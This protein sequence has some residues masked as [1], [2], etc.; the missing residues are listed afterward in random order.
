MNSVTLLTDF[1]AKD[2]YVGIMKGVILAINPGLSIVDITHEVEPQD[3]REGAFLIPEY[4]RYFR[5]GT[6]HLCVVD[7]TVGSPRKAMIAARDGHVFV[8]PD[9]GL[10]TM[11]LD[12]A[13]L[14]EITNER[15]FLGEASATFNGRD[16]FSPVAAHLTLGVPPREFGPLLENPVQLAG[17]TPEVRDDRLRG[18]IVKFDRFG[19]AISNISLEDIRSFSGK[20]P[21][22]V[23]I[24]DLS[25]HG[26]NRSYYED[27]QTALIGSSGY[28]EFG[29][30]E[31]NMARE[32]GFVKG[33]QVTVRRL[34]DA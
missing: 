18:E 2:P 17:M 8:G 4:Y 9:N 16:I 7:P 19:N 32:K 28:L 13:D 5:P 23:E 15:F 27:T 26:L 6:V 34:A 25:F 29:L 22:V 11:I 14:Y 3:I 31:G 10:F 33:T 12:G 21:C 24:G 20:G 1:G 30:F